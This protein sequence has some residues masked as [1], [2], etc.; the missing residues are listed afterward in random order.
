MSGEVR[1]FVRHVGG[2]C[3]SPPSV[4]ECSMNSRLC[5]AISEN[6]RQ[7][8]RIRDTFWMPLVLAAAANRQ[9]DIQSSW[10][11]GLRRLAHVT[12]RRFQE[13][14][15]PPE[16]VCGWVERAARGWTVV[17]RAV[18]TEGPSQRKRS[19]GMRDTSAVNNDPASAVNCQPVSGTLSSRHPHSHR[20]PLCP[21][22]PKQ[23]WRWWGYGGAAVIMNIISGNS[24]NWRRFWWWWR[25]QQYSC[26]EEF[27]LFCSLILYAF[28]EK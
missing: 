8:S 6:T 11:I 24:S 18:L 28:Y 22:G 19:D 23:C 4:E 1:A 20:Q 25:W 17:W 13:C 14:H 27:G 7:R 21:R 15:L 9:P 5:A 16:S 2:R 12:R 26:L 10:P 3:P